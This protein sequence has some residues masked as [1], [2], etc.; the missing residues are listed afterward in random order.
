[1]KKRSFSFVILVIA[2]TGVLLSG[3]CTRAKPPSWAQLEMLL[4]PAGSFRMGS[5]D[6]AR[7]QPVHNVTL[8][9]D[10]YISKYEIT[11]QQYAEMLNYALSKG[12]LDISLLTQGEAH[13]GEV[14]GVS[15]RPVKYQDVFDEHSRITFK[16]GKFKPHPGQEKHPVVEVTWNG[17]A[18]FCNMLNKVSGLEPLYNLDDWSCQVY[19]KT[20]YRLP[21]EAEWEYAAKYN[22]N[23]AFPWGN[24]EPDQSRAQIKQYI[25][26]P[27][28]VQTAPVGTFS[29]AGDSELG[30]CDMVGNVAEWVNDWYN[31]YLP[32]D[33]VDPVGPPPSFFVNLPVFKEFRPLRVLRGGSFLTDPD[34]RKGMGPPFVMDSVIHPEAFNNSFRTYEY[35]GLSRQ[36]QGFRVV[37]ITARRSTKPAFSAAEK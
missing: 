28:D 7:S 14:R 25:N 10:F 5:P 30:I 21:T 37:K 35:R 2:F 29:P 18:F 12:Y 26:D 8:T 4:V 3:S 24:T 20:G 33:A 27:S 1:M 11:N 9:N 23:R 32:Q 19:G 16:D 15:K 13:K 34:Y 22:D 6:F 17:A 36:T 31:Y